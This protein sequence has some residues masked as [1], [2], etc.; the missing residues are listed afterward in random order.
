MHLSLKFDMR[1]LLPIYYNVKIN[2]SFEI[3]PRDYTLII[4]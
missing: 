3:Q 4:D 2:N 1:S